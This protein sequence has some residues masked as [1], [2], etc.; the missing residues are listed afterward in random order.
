MEKKTSVPDEIKEAEEKNAIRPR[1]LL[2]LP[3]DLETEDRRYL[4]ASPERVDEHKDEGYEV[5]SGPKQQPDGQTTNV[6]SVYETRG[7]VL[8]VT[9]EANAKAMEA[10]ERALADAQSASASERMTEAKG[11]IEYL[12][13]KQGYSRREVKEFM[14]MFEERLS[15]EKI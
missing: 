12:L 6:S 5:V 2:R 4:W 1:S 15:R 10:H 3:T 14:G 9:S 13:S 11:E 8:M 7:M